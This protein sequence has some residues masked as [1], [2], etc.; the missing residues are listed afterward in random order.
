MVNE[1]GGFTFLPSLLI[2]GSSYGWRSSLSSQT[3]KT[4]L[5]F[6][7]YQ[8]HNSVVISVLFCTAEL[9]K[10]CLESIMLWQGLCGLRAQLYT[11]SSASIYHCGTVGKPLVSCMSHYPFINT[12]Y[13]PR[14]SCTRLVKTAL[15]ERLANRSKM[16]WVDTIKIY[17]EKK[18]E[19]HRLYS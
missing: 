3:G 12:E 18:T 7:Q 9:K 16:L 5:E 14:S 19:V 13:L 10:C 6:L 17:V 2:M 4:C 1:P 8:F 15:D 11:S